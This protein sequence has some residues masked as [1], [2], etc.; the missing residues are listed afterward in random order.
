MKGTVKRSCRGATLWLVAAVFLL[1]GAAAL[2]QTATLEGRV[3][4]E[5]GQPA[6]G[7]TLTATKPDTGTVRVLQTASDG[8]YRF[9]SLPVGTWNLKAELGGYQTVE[10]KG[11]VLAVAT[12]RRVEVKLSNEVKL[13]EEVNVTATVPV[14]QSEPAAGTVVSQVELKTLPLNGRQFANLGAL[15]PGT[16][17]AHNTDPTKP[18]QL[19]IAL[20]GGSGRNVN[21]TVDGGDN[22][23]DTIGGALQN[24]S[25]ESVDQFNIQTQQYKA[26]YG[27]S[28]GG[29]LTVVTKS[30]T[31]EFHGSVFGFGRN[32][33]LN[34]RSE[35]EK[36]AEVD[37]ADYKRYQYGGSFG[38]P[39]VRDKA[40]FFA[41]YE[42]TK[43]DTNYIVSTGG[44]FPELDGN[45]VP[46][47]FRDDL[48]SAKITINP[49]PRQLIQIR[50]GY[51]KN[52]GTYGAAPNYTPDA[53]GTIENKYQSFL[54]SHQWTLP[55]GA[56]N[57][58]L[59]QY[60][61]FSN[62]ITAVSKNPAL[63]FPSGVSS[64]Q[65]FNT[66][67]TTEQT[68]YQLKEDFS[69]GREIGGHRHDFKVGF[70]IIHE[71]KLGGDFSTGVDAPQYTFAADSLD[72]PIIH[73]LQFGGHFV[74]STPIDEYSVYAQDDWRV[75]TNLTLNVGLRYDLW[76]GFDLDQTSNPI[77]QYLSQQ[78]TYNESY[79]QD[80]QGGKGGKL[81][82]DTNNF[83]PRLGFTYD[84]HGDQKTI[85]RGGFGIYYDFPYTNATILFPAGA[86]QSNYGPVYEVTNP[87]G[88]R[89]PDGS[90][91]QL[92]DPLPPNELPGLS[93]GAPREIASPTLAT[94]Y[95]RQFSLGVSHMLNSWLGLNVEA[96]V[97][98]YRDIPYRFR[99]NVTDPETEDPRFPFSQAIRMWYGKGF[100]DYRGLNIG[101]RARIKD[102]FTA[103][104]FYT[105][106]KADGN[107]LAGAD[108]FR[109]SDRQYQ[110][111][112]PRDESVNP[113]DPGCS[114]CV[115]P[116]NTDA[117]HKVTLAATYMAPFDINVS[118]LFRY[119]SATPYTL[120]SGSDGVQAFLQ[121]GVGNVNSAR[122]HSF[123]QFDL[124]ASK[125]I[126]IH[127]FG[128]IEAIFE[129]FNVLN[130]KNPAGYTAAGTPTLYAGD[131]F[132]GE[133][134]LAQI[135][136][137]A[138]F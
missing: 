105:I 67:Q 117:R 99:F 78:T 106:S 58:L 104:A 86:V 118:G 115:G 63:Y 28:T 79:L 35:S 107:V 50:Y 45:A 111:G 91:F 26:E 126:P 88:I 5:K 43:R 39:I 56:V 95:S 9:A 14:I 38:G 1:S 33:S 47:P 54:V 57:E 92:G 4:D 112:F 134:R 96:N 20:S 17:L 138:T 132:Q 16:Q 127:G 24:Y 129:I 124:R 6:P 44:I 108:E 66:P 68:K 75:S 135:G 116:L 131:P 13:S 74:N 110:P 41:T 97:I 82:N 102:K 53:L 98:A 8:T 11:I 109:I 137:R 101:L 27:R 72:S 23:D 125:N 42:K 10:R 100:A 89:N 83:A 114:A 70:N 103:Q 130:E 81:K 60:S 71:P 133:Q 22:T 46:T 31:N 2:A 76:R 120:F 94:P 19:T 90:F 93:V 84:L 113:L 12:T 3:V 123:S 69:W 119:R 25:V 29:V 64:G 37:K 34:T 87:D 128:A 85:L 40:F 7:V 122:G 30:G 52:T 73:I 21:F 59:F 49:D 65:N 18:D 77:W 51:Q 48:A 55:G 80:F 32:Q 121:P 36:L 61:T 136:L 15:A 62:A